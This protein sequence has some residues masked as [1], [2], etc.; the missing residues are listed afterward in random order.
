MYRAEEYRNVG[1]QT[2]LPTK[3][4]EEQL[5]ENEV[6]LPSEQRLFKSSPGIQE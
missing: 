5:Q 6:S 3:L 2:L 1:E 4:L